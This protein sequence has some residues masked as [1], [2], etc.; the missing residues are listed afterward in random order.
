M[1]K[2]PQIKSQILQKNKIEIQ[3]SIFT[4]NKENISPAIQN[5]QKTKTNQKITKINIKNSIII[6]KKKLNSDFIKTYCRIRPNEN[7][8]NCIKNF[9]I[10]ENDT[11]LTVKFLDGNC[12]LY[13]FTKIFG[14]EKKNEDVFNFV[15]KDFLNDFVNLG[16]SGLIFVYGFS[17]SGKS[18]TMEGDEKI[19]GI[20]Q[21]SFSEIFSLLRSKFNNNNL[22]E[23]TCTFIEIYNESIYDLLSETRTKLKLIGKNNLFSVKNATFHAIKTENDFLNTLNTGLKNRSTHSTNLNQ[24]SSRSH[25]IFRI[26]LTQNENF[27]SISFV[28]LAGVE[29]ANRANTKGE[30]L[31]EAGNINKSLLVL[32]SCIECMEINTQ[33]T[34]VDKKVR[35]PIRESKLTMIFK[36]YFMNDKNIKIIANIN[37]TLDDMFDNKNVLNFITKASKVK[38]IKSWIEEIKNNNNKRVFHMFTTKKNKKINKNNNENSSESSVIEMSNSSSSDFD[39]EMEFNTNNNNNNHSILKERKNHV[40][41][42]NNSK[43]K[44]HLV[45]SKSNSNLINSNYKNKIKTQ[46]NKKCNEFLVNS[47]K[48]NNN[49]NNFSFKKKDILSNKKIENNLFFN[50]SKNKNDNNNNNILNKIYNTNNNKIIQNNQNNFNI[51]NNPSESQISI[52]SNRHTDCKILKINIIIIIKPFFGRN[53]FRPAKSTEISHIISLFIIWFHDFP[54]P[55]FKKNIMIQQMMIMT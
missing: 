29:R 25:I 6:Q 14:I 16:K 8:N 28:D 26:E 12:Y 47:E 17:N 15:C 20:L 24:N 43:S 4:Q 23:L 2:T 46:S 32:R 30:N 9:D 42:N 3:P 40:K 39:S 35:V 44:N 11:K 36:E 27:S 48:K 41:S 13:N 10:S 1:S 52:N 37:P 31:K 55:F 19:K 21:M 45:Y 34:L 50:K 33:N 53:Y 18:Y 7:N 38:P 49:I 5:S 54:F 22:F 51:Q